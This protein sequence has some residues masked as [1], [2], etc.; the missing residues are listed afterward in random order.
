MAHR[1]ARKGGTKGKQGNG[2][3][4]PAIGK[5]EVGHN[6]PPLPFFFLNCPSFVRFVYFLF[7]CPFC[8]LSYCVLWIF[9]LRKI[10]RLRSGAN[11]RSWVPEASTQTPRPPKPLAFERLSELT[12]P[13]RFEWTAPFH[14]KTKT[15]L[16]A[17]A[18]TSRT[19]SNTCM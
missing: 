6:L 18:V 16:C 3:G 5:G 19:S 1:C 2:V 13:R 9:P 4:N 8:V 10:R 14:S 17:I 15:S 11:P 7:K 12:P